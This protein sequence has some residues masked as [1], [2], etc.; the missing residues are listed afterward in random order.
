MG[1]ETWVN[2]RPI[3]I[4]I[5]MIHKGGGKVRGAIPDDDVVDIA[6]EKDDIRRERVLLPNVVIF[7]ITHG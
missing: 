5:A 1:S 7:P 6:S 4:V 2:D 3:G